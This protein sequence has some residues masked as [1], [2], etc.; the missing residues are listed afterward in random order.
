MRKESG[1]LSRNQII[2]KIGISG[3]IWDQLCFLNGNVPISTRKTEGKNRKIYFSRKKV[4]KFKQDSFLKQIKYIKIWKKSLYKSQRQSPLT[5]KKKKFQ[6]F[7]SYSFEKI[8]KKRFPDFLTAFSKVDQIFVQ[9]WLKDY[10]LQ[11][12]SLVDRIFH[13]KT[14]FFEFFF[15]VKN[16]GNLNCIHITKQCFHMGLRCFGSDIKFIFPR[17]KSLGKKIKNKKKMFSSFFEL[18]M[19]LFRLLTNKLGKIQGNKLLKYFITN[20]LPSLLEFFCTKK[21]IYEKSIEKKKFDNFNC[22]IFMYKL[23]LKIKSI[24]NLAYT[25][26]N[27]TF[28]KNFDFFIFKSFLKGYIFFAQNL[29]KDEF[30][31]ILKLF[32][33]LKNTKNIND[34][35]IFGFFFEKNLVSISIL[36]IKLSLVWLYSSLNAQTIFPIKLV[37]QAECILKKFN[38]FYS[39]FNKNKKFNSG[40]F[41]RK[42]QHQKIFETEKDSLKKKNTF[43]LQSTKPKKPKMKTFHTYKNLRCVNKIL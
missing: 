31:F 12:N 25:G 43:F 29:F 9:I 35:N 40:I 37:Q 36:S 14:N 7:P 1:V 18:N 22:T 33:E 11:D 39:K 41:R 13:D 30:F 24:K 32:L 17:I 5:F 42:F 10:I 16:I 15:F 27:F 20:K 19:S 23:H 26:K 8:V 21:K 38:P 4:K 34:Q 2:K 3:Y 6:F 28:S